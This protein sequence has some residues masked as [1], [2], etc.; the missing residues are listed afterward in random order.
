MRNNRALCVRWNL[1]SVR[2][3]LIDFATMRQGV[4]ARKLRWSLRQRI[5]DERLSARQQLIAKIRYGGG[6]RGT[7]RSMA[8]LRSGLFVYDL[9]LYLGRRVSCPGLLWI[10]MPDERVLVQAYLAKEPGLLTHRDLQVHKL[11][12]KSASRLRLPKWRE[13]LR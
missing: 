3:N 12:F 11:A 8:G 7:T 13:S 1:H 2:R 5:G 9:F 4:T 6:R 10:Y